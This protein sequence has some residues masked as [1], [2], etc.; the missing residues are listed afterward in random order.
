VPEKSTIN[1]DNN[2]KS[3]N[4]NI[5]EKHNFKGKIMIAKSLIQSGLAESVKIFYSYSR[6]DSVERDLIEEA[7]ASFEWDIETEAWKRD[8][9]LQ[10][11]DEG[12]QGGEKW[13]NEIKEYLNIADII[14][15][16]VTKNFFKSEYI[17]NVEIRIALE[18]ERRGDARVIPILIDKTNPSWIESEFGYLQPLPQNCLPVNDWDKKEDALKNVAQGIVDIIVREGLLPNNRSRWQLQLETDIEVFEH[19]AQKSLIENLRRITKDKTLRYLKIKKGSVIIT[20]DSSRESLNK[21]IE[22]N[23]DGILQKEIGYSIISIN[24]LFGAH[25]QEGVFI[26]GKDTFKRPEK[27][28]EPDLMLLPSKPF[29]PILMKGIKIYKDDPFNFNTIIDSGNDLSKGLHFDKEVYK[30]M[31]YFF[32]AIATPSDD[33]F[34]NLAPDENAI[35]LSETLKNTR[36]GKDLLEFD[37]KLKR[38]SASLLHPDIESGK[39]FWSRVFDKTKKIIGSENIPLQAFQR[40]WIEADI[41]KVYEGFSPESKNIQNNNEYYDQ[42]NFIQAFI[43]KKHLKAYSK[44]ADLDQYFS[45]NNPLNYRINEI[46]NENFD[47]MILPIIE[48]EV[49]EGESFADNRQIFNCLILASWLKL[50]KNKIPKLLEIIDSKKPLDLIKQITKMD[51]KYPDENINKSH[52]LNFE[53]FTQNSNNEFNSEN[54]FRN[55]AGYKIYENRLYYEKYLDVFKNGVFYLERYDFDLKYNKKIPRVY[56]A[57]A[58]DFRNI[59]TIINH[60]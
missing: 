10:W 14:L 24:E 40:V 41:A 6:K 4:D 13:D 32:T 5:Y 52:L 8:K 45:L 54:F 48:N 27:I 49:N 44:K 36:L 31:E 29:I 57:G 43:V 51:I 21:I 56:F 33:I 1:I 12:I 25:I 55:S 2:L 17:K 37:Y 26:S 11:Y 39:E 60:E 34:V 46:I 30:L 35:L 16:F 22:L 42:A 38:L 19:K 15:L 3:F 58:I 50:N 23:H 59:E 7:I 9:V 18:R 53:N 28:P 20:I 47:D